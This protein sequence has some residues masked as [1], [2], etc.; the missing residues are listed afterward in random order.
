MGTK[1]IYVKKENEKVFD[2][3]EELFEDSLSQVIVDSLEK[4]ME[5]EK[6]K[7]EGMRKQKL[8]IGVF[9]HEE[10]REPNYK[11]V[12]FYGKKLAEHTIR[13]DRTMHEG[14][15]LRLFI[16]R[17]NKYLLFVKHW[18]ESKYLGD[19]TEYII[20]DNLVDVEEDGKATDSLIRKAKESLNRDSA[21][22]LDI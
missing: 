8:K 18:C 11:I 15:N 22:F 10:D 2:R 5:I 19:E 3:A 14:R 6:A 9:P 12:K 16:T 20:Y 21:E 4:H 17:K 13:D 1:T 7:N